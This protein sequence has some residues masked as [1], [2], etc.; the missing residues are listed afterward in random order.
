[1]Y[2]DHIC[3]SIG[4]SFYT[5]FTVLINVSLSQDDYGVPSELQRQVIGY[6][7]YLWVRKKGILSEG[8]Y[9]ALPMSFKAEIS[10]TTNSGILE[11]VQSNPL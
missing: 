9:D 11:K 6:Y 2:K 7:E 5:R 4:W 1:M 3:W 10:H 8:I